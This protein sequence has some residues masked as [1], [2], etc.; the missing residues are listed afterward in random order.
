MAGGGRAENG[1]RRWRRLTGRRLGA[2]AFLRQWRA[3]AAAWRG[4]VIAAAEPMAMRVGGG[5]GGGER[6]RWAMAMGI[7]GGGG[8]ARSRSRS[9]SDAGWW[10]RRGAALMGDG[11]G[12]GADAAVRCSIEGPRAGTKLI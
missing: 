6:R 5:G 2:I 10:R 7:G 9:G 12:S 4:R 3:V 1:G 11:D 8:L